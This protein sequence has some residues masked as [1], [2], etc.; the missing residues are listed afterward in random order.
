METAAEL[1]ENY[2]YALSRISALSPGARTQQIGP[3]LCVD[4]AVEEA[5]FNIA[6]LMPGEGSDSAGSDTLHLVERWFANRERGWRLI[7]RSSED[8]REIT[9]ARRAGYQDGE[10]EPVM[11][12]EPLTP[13]G[14]V[15]G[16]LSIVRVETEQDILDYARAEPG[17]AEDLEMRESMT[18]A[19]MTVPGCTMYVGRIGSAPVGRSMAL[20]TGEVVGVYNVF[21][22]PEWRRRGFGAALTGS[23][24][25]EGL[26]AGC[27]RCCLEAT[28]LGKPMYERLGFRV[29]D[30][31][32]SLWAPESR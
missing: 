12:L 16:L 2:V 6:T 25:A 24:L 29:V 19:A 18:R 23:V 20:V 11:V 27:A 21:V 28:A 4:A 17:D 30:H 22:R 1:H 32:L 26:V 8:R 13:R 9:A 15:N 31:Y 3:W 10:R 14:P 5:Y 7:L